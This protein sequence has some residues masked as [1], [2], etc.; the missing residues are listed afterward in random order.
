MTRLHSPA[1]PFHRLNWYIMRRG[2]RSI[3][4]FVSIMRVPKEAPRHPNADRLR[5][6]SRFRS[7]LLQTEDMQFGK[8]YFPGS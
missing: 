8:E 4:P 1:F 2:Q 5:V 6:T 7:D 3:A